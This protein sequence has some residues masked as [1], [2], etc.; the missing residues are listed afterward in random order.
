MEINESTRIGEL[1]DKYPWLKD[2]AVK[3]HEKFRLL[4]NPFIL[5]LAKKA[6]LKD[7]SDRAGIPMEQVTQTLREMLEKHGV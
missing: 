6:T 5:A 3:I 1:L 2:E 4:E 7:L